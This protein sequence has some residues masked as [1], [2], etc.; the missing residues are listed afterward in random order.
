MQI[1]TTDIKRHIYVYKIQEIDSLGIYISETE[2][3]EKALE[4][5]RED[6]DAEKMSLS[7]TLWTWDEYKE[8]QGFRVSEKILEIIS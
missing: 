3:K 1:S 5:I 2:M 7:V 8:L 4:M 6:L